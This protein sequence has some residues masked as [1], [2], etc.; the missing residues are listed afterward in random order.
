MTITT[1]PE[2]LVGCG[3]LFDAWTDMM[4]SEFNEKLTR[5]DTLDSGDTHFSTAGICPECDGTC[6]C[7]GDKR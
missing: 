1:K 5:P 6:G 7:R 4:L 2:D 3:Q